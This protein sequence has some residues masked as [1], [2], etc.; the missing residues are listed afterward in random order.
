M[1]SPNAAAITMLLSISCM[2]SLVIGEVALITDEK[3]EPFTTTRS[4]VTRGSK[5]APSKEKPIIRKEKVVS[6]QKVDSHD[7][8]F[9]LTA[10]GKATPTQTARTTPKPSS[11]PAHKPSFRP[12]SQPVTKLHVNNGSPK[13][14]PVEIPSQSYHW[15][16]LYPCT[17]IPWLIMCSADGYHLEVTP[18][19][20]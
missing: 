10:K 3:K 6:D 20:F 11:K 2:A 14:N 15:K 17:Y 19:F 4:L 1:K 7:A 16:Q 5:G 13:N 8:A 12:T 18:Y 9:E